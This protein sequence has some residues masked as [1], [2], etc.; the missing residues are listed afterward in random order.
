MSY[1]QKGD[2][3]QS[4]VTA[5]GMT[6]YGFYTVLS[7]DEMVTPFGSFCTYWLVSTDG[8]QLAVNNLHL[9]AD[10]QVHPTA[11]ATVTRK[12]RAAKGAGKAKQVRALKAQWAAAQDKADDLRRKG[13]SWNAAEAQRKANELEGQLNRLVWGG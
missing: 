10:K 1:F 4:K 5:Q 2:V 11:T 12:R 6:E 8:R 3:V 9:L 13:L 7:V